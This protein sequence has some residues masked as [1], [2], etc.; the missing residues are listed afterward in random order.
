MIRKLLAPA[1]GLA[2]MMSSGP[3]PAEEESPILPGFWEARASTF[4]PL[5]TERKC[6]TA[7]EVLR[8]VHGWSNSVY[9][10][11]YP[12]SVV[13]GGKITWRGNC[14]SRG[15]RHL[16]ITADGSYTAT[17]FTV[18]GK[19]RSELR[20]STWTLPVTVKSRRLGD[21]N[22]FDARGRRIAQ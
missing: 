21:C 22:E 13:A 11:T 9:T 7:A 16:T 17:S 20:G 6:L 18:S 15:G 4:I 5:S 8:A 3:A 1:V 14:S 2:V 19:I 12:V 10:C